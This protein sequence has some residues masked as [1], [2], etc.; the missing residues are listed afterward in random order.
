MRLIQQSADLPQER[1]LAM[2][3]YFGYTEEVVDRDENGN[4]QENEDG[5][6]KMKAVPMLDW[7]AERYNQKPLEDLKEFNLFQLRQQQAIE[8]AQAETQVEQV[9]SQLI[10]VTME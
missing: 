8:L 1:F 3:Q 4:A 5:T 10:S 2:A 9:I 6:T 7:Y